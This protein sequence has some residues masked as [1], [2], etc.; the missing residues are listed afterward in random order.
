M[1]LI[2]VVLNAPDMWNDTIRIMEEE[3]AQVRKEQVVQAGEICA[4]VPACMGR[5]DA[6]CGGGERVFAAAG[7]GEGGNQGF[8]P[9]P[10]K[11][12]LQSGRIWGMLK[13]A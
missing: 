8:C 11:A 12:R 4:S 5:R 2:T 7:G 9:K 10:S 3:F 1:Q 6:G 13:S